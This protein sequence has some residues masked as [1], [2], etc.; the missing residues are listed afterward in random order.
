MKYYSID[1]I[2]NLHPDYGLIIGGRSNGK[3]HATAQQWIKN[4][5][6]TG[7]QFVR[8]IRYLFDMQGKYVANYFDDNLLA[9]LAKE[10]NKEIWY[11]APYYYINDIGADKK[12]KDIIGY[13]L[14]LSNEQKYKSNQYDRVTIIDVEEFALM[15]PT[16]YLPMESEKFLSLVSTIVRSRKNV[17]IWFVGNTI[18]KYNPYFTLLNINIDKLQLKPGDLKI[19]QQPDL[20]YDESPLVAIEFAEMAYEDM[21][22]IPRVLKVGQN[23]TATNGLYVTPPDVFSK[24]NVQ[25]DKVNKTFIV[26]IGDRKFKFNIFP[27]F[28]YWE[29]CYGKDKA[30]R[31]DM[32]VRTMCY[33]KGR[34]FWNV[35]DKLNKRPDLSEKIPTEMYYDSEETKQYVYENVIRSWKYE[36]RRI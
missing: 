22:E 25:F 10:Y 20:G 21:K 6:K 30:L 17:S 31:P 16:Q 3:S 19:I 2:W 14:A 1:R 27:C 8:I 26:Q 9:W 33:D 12:N 15:D 28:C 34:Y 35:V 32:L 36:S 23:D 4:Y 24:D 5:L 13:V 18:S 7:A 29:L 11:D